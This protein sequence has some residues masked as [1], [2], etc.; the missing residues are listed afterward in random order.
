M[1]LNITLNLYRHTWRLPGTY[2]LRH[3]HIKS[4]ILSLKP[5]LGLCT[6]T[7]VSTSLLLSFCALE[8]LSPFLFVCCSSSQ[9]SA[10]Q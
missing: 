9:S 6:R 5:E 4:R 3:Q 1:T 2:I 7:T 10:R 8:S